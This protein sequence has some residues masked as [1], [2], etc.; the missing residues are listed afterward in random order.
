M[1]IS[2]ISLALVLILSA[3]IL[4]HGQA[5]LTDDSST[6]SA[7]PK[8]NYGSSIAVIV[9]SGSNAYFKFS[10]ANLGASVNGNN[11][12]TATL[13][14]YTDAVLTSGTMDVYQVNGPWSEAR[15]LG[16]A[17]LRWVQRF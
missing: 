1:K 10:L 13:V 2:K 6:S 14:L 7:T 3:T 4:A 5:V 17:R 15:S 16:T 9:A 12:S 11:V 8:A